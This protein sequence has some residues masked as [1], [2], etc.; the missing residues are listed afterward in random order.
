MKP[1]IGRIVHFNF[2][3]PE[4]RRYDAMVSVFPALVVAVNH[5]SVDLVVFRQNGFDFVLNVYEDEKGGDD[6]VYIGNP[7]TWFWPPRT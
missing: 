6:S 3:E 7:G 4:T 5:D 2:S 1:T